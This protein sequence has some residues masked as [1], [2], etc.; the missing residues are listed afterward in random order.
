MNARP[1]MVCRTCAEPLNSWHPFD[2]PDH[3]EWQHGS[4]PDRDHPPA[5]IP[6]TENLVV[7]QICD[8]C[9]DTSVR[10]IY[11]TETEMSHI[12]ATPTFTGKDHRHRLNKDWDHV[13]A[14]QAA[15]IDHRLDVFSTGWAA[16][17]DCAD[18]L[19]LRDMEGLITRLRRHK[20]DPF[21]QLARNVLRRIYRPL[22]RSIR[23]RTT[24]NPIT[25]HELPDE[26]PPA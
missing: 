14:E 17:H 1:G 25:G 13:T 11:H 22:F 8:F 9:A 23:R 20:P 2:Q 21:A 10:W 18:Y 16:C 24:V 12:L 4:D 3:I 19:E 5:P 15:A 6:R 7:H 26:D